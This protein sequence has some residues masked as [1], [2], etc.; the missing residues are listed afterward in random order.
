M[1]TPPNAL[2]AS[3]A[4]AAALSALACEGP[5]PA[6][7]HMDPSGPFKLGSAGAREQVKVA[8]K[9]DKGRPYTRPLDV[10]YATSD[11]GVASVADDGTITATGSGDAVITASASGLTT[12]ADVRV[13][14]VGSVELEPGTPPKWSLRRGGQHTLKAVVKDDKGHVMDPVPN[15][16]F[17]TSDHCI[18]MDPDG[19][20]RPVSLGRCDAVATV[21]GHSARVTVE[22]KD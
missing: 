22:V 18:D 7:L 1:R 13:R 11:P 9:D 17:S 21:A 4:L 10:S 8:A 5:V 3:L 15:V 2:V 14:I 19:T 6:A 20:F 12:A 16:V